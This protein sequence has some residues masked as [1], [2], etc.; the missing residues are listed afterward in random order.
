MYRWKKTESS[1]WLTGW[2]WLDAA[3]SRLISRKRR[4]GLDLPW[5]LKILFW[6]V[7]E[8]LLPEARPRAMPGNGFPGMAMDGITVSD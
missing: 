8:R 1:M 7:A 3:P 5:C 6:A 4:T 2:F